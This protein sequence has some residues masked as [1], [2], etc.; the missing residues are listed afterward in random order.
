MGVSKN[1]CCE[2]CYL[3]TMGKTKKNTTSIKQRI[4]YG[5][6]SF[7]WFFIG[8]FLAGGILLSILLAYFELRYQERV[9]PG[10]FVGKIYVGGKTPQEVRNIFEEKNKTLENNTFVFATELNEATI[11]AKE[12]KAGYDTGLIVEQAFSIGKRSNLISNVYQIFNSYLNGAYIKTSYSYDSEKLNNFIKPLQNQI[13]QEPTDAQFRVE[14]KRVIAFQESKNGRTID[15]ELLEKEISKRVEAMLVEKNTKL[16]RV[17]LPVKILYPKLSTEQANSFGIAEI[18]GEGK[19]QFQHSIPNRIY[20]VSLA[21]SKVSG[22][23]VAP[24]EEFSFAKYLGDVSRYTGYKEAYVIKE[25]KTV[26]GDGGGVCQVSTTLFR[27][28]LNSGLPITERT[29][30]AYRVGYYEQDSE[31]GF[32]ATVF[33]PSVD[34]KFKNDTNNYILIQS[35]IDAQNLT[36]RYVIYGKKDGRETSISK[37]VISNQ[38][39]PPPPLYQDDPTLPLGIVKQIDFDAPGARVVFTRIVKKDGKIIISETFTSNFKAWQAIY[40]RGTKT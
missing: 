35:Y 11:S 19:S 18:I 26:L 14:N 37:P 12:I 25:G 22:I 31:P 33:V 1:P 2:K 40:L 9:I 29:A 16:L 39:A 27:A 17:L 5:A 36:L 28:V 4:Y 13:F 30:H 6:R 15:I 7:F 8:F 21:A 20:N 23:L 10:V 24:N 38:S 34:L 3:N 32:D